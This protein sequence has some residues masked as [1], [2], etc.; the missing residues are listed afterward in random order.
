MGRSMVLLTLR[1]PSMYYFYLLVMPASNYTPKYTYTN[2]IYKQ[3]M[4]IFVDD[5]TKLTLHGLQQYYIRY[6]TFFTFL[7]P[8]MTK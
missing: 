3:P 4:E 2:T 1:T 5:D 6:I 8:Y 7:F